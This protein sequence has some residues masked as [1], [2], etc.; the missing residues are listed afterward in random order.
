MS[1][2][3]SSTKYIPM[4]KFDWLTSFYDPLMDELHIADW[5]K[6]QNT[7]IRCAFYVVQMPYGEQA[8][9]GVV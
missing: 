2:Q 6:P 9:L 3:H 1:M 7:I 8:S 5:G 4:P